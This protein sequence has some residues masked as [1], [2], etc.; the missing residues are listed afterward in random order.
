MT[1][2]GDLETRVIKDDKTTRDLPNATHKIIDMF[3]LAIREQGSNLGM[4]TQVRDKIQT[5]EQ[6]VPLQPMFPYIYEVNKRYRLIDP[7]LLR[8]TLEFRQTNVVMQQNQ[9]TLPNKDCRQTSPYQNEMFQATDS[10]WT[11]RVASQ[12]LAEVTQ[13]TECPK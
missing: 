4:P 7:L 13:E 1:T 12:Q 9:G 2:Q 10:V 6:R 8:P 3:R 5:A 11:T